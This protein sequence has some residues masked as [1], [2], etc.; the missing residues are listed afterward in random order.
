M[1]STTELFNPV[2]HRKAKVV[3]NLAILSAMGLRGDAISLCDNPV[4]ASCW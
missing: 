3:C 4:K 2:A 1:V